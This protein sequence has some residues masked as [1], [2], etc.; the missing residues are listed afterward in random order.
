MNSGVAWGGPPRAAK[1]YLHLK[2][3]EG[4]KYF[5][6]GI[7]KISGFKKKVVKDFLAQIGK[8]VSKGG[9]VKSKT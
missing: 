9:G 7:G 1:L 6:A 4:G 2:I 5:E 8:K 3:W